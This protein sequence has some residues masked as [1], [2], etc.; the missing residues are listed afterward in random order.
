MIIAKCARC[1]IE[2]LTSVANRRRDDLRC[3]FGCRQAR[4]KEQNRKRGR[5]NYETQNGKEAKQRRNRKRY[6]KSHSPP[7]EVPPK[8]PSEVPFRWSPEIIL[9]L[10]WIIR[11]VLGYPITQIQIKEWLMELFDRFSSQRSLRDRGG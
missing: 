11:T 7:R 8:L 6:L 10:F 2:F 3:P 1:D 4:K 5:K 9:Y